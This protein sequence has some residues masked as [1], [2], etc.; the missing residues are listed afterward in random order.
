MSNHDGGY[1]L[2]EVLL[3]LEK[4]GFFNTLRQQEIVDFAKD[5]VTIGN[6]HDCND[7]EIFNKIGRRMKYC[8]CCRKFS[9]EFDD[10][11]VCKDCT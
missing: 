1:M 2:N 11:G 3:L 4:Y 5:I 8:Y 9:E 6:D 7:G 10:D